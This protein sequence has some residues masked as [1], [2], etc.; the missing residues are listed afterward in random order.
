[1]SAA[2]TVTLAWALVT[3]AKY[4]DSLPL[5]GFQRSAGW[6]LLV[7]GLAVFAARTGWLALRFSAAGRRSSRIG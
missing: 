2:L 6:V 5:T 1:M 7:L 4:H 3:W